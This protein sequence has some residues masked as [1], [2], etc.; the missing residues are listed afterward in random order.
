MARLLL[1]AAL[2][3]PLAAGA[4][5]IFRTVDADGNTVYTD[6]PPADT[7]SSE[8]VHQHQINTAPP[9]PARLEEPP[10]ADA[11][12]GEDS[13]AGS[14]SVAITSPANETSVPMGPGNFA[15]NVQ[16]KPALGEQDSLQLYIDGVPSGKPQPGTTWALTNVFRGAHDLTVAILN[17]DGQPVATSAPSRVFVH[18]PSVNFKNRN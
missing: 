10:A 7:A 2:L 6:N 11:T 18:R 4:Q 17:S 15:V 13:A 14:Y 12:A 5:Q 16:V 1:L 8:K 3:I 9:P